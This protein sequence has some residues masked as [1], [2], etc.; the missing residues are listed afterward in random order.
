MSAQTMEI[1][2]CMKALILEPDPEALTDARAREDALNAKRYELRDS[3]LARMTDGS[4]DAPTGVIFI[5]IAT[6]LEEIGDHAFNVVEAT[7]GLK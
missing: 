1:L 5:D 3:Y 6:S 4:F 7:V 2:R